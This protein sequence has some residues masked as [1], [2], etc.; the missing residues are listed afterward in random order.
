MSLT[1][2]CAQAPSGTKNKST[3]VVVIFMSK[4]PW[5]NLETPRPGDHEQL[6][7]EVVSGHDLLDI[8]GALQFECQTSDPR[9]VVVNGAGGVGEAHRAVERRFPGDFSQTGRA[10]VI[11]GEID[12]QALDWADPYA[13]LPHAIDG[14]V[15]QRDVGDRRGA[16]QKIHEIGGKKTVVAES[17]ISRGAVV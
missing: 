9:H 7:A 16:A 6:R 15:A 12:Y 3:A 2:C 8:V 17:G 5:S 4:T 1:S 14:L 13:G 11:A 10:N